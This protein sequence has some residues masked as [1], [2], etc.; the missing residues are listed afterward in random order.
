MTVDELFKLDDKGYPQ[1]TA[2]AMTLEPLR[3]ILKK[4]NLLYGYKSHMQST[5][6]AYVY[7]YCNKDLYVAYNNRQ[8]PLAIKRR[9]QLP[10]DWQPSEEV[11]YAIDM[12]VQDSETVPEKAVRVLKETLYQFI[13]VLD[14]I[15]KRNS[16]KLNS[17]SNI[18]TD[19]LNPI[20]EQMRKETLQTLFEDL[21]KTIKLNTLLP[22]ALDEIEK[23]EQKVKKQ[24]ITDKAVGSKVI[25]KY[26]R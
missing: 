6:L 23:L 22:K 7:F 12:L 26:E 14:S 3:N 11:K 25:S 13:D 18:K 20:D 4:N 10:D 19:T 5:E 8:R 2:V 15:G 9:L 16:E 1:V 21:E 24:E 17:L